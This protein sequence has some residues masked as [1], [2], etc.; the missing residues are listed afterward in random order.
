MDLL[1]HTLFPYLLG[2]Y[3]TKR[4]EEITALVIGGIAP[5]FDYL[6]LWIQNV[7]PTFFLITHR[8]ITHSLFFGFFRQKYFLCYGRDYYTPFS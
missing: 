2:N 5:D 8:G 3:F 6:L 4:K 1:S 7:Y